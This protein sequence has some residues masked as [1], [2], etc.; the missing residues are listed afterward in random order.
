MDNSRPHLICHR[1]DHSP[2]TGL[3]AGKHLADDKV[4]TERV[5]ADRDQGDNE[6]RRMIVP[7][8]AVTTPVI[9]ASL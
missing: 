1:G 8:I 5:V 4:V 6:E 9:P 2:D 7:M 3:H